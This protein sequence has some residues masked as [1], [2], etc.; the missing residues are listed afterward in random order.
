MNDLL[1][2]GTADGERLK[3]AGG[4]AWIAENAHVLEA[5]IDAA[6]QRGDTVKRVEID[7]GAVDQLDTFGAWLLEQLTRSFSSRGCDTKVIGLKED[8]RALIA[9]VHGVKSEQGGP[10]LGGPYSRLGR[11]NCRLRRRN[12]CRLR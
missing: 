11:G 4:G 8:Y 3:L 6:T 12:V 7:M 5:Q 10:R 2:Q 9:E 1:L